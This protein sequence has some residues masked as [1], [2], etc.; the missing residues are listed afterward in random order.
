MF[1][2]SLFFTICYHIRKYADRE[3]SAPGPPFS[4]T[5]RAEREMK[6]RPRP[7]LVFPSTQPTTPSPSRGEEPAEYPNQNCPL[8]YVSLF[9]G[10]NSLR[11]A[12]F[13][14]GTSALTKLS[15]ARRRSHYPINGLLLPY[16]FMDFTPY[17]RNGCHYFPNMESDG[18]QLAKKESLSVCKGI[19]PSMSLSCR[20]DRTC[21][22]V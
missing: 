5:M 7:R 9:I 10:R 6:H 20:F 8:G 16:N 12:V 15:R 14:R 1:K 22:G 11:L 13:R 4:M 21:T 2:A 3:L 17:Q 18:C 19:W